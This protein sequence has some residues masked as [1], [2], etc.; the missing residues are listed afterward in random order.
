MSVRRVLSRVRAPDEDGAEARAWAVVRTSYQNRVPNRQRRRRVRL[1]LLCML[2]LVAIAGAVTLSPAGTSVARWVKDTLGVRHAADKLFAL[3]SPGSV[4]VSGPRGTW[5]VTADGS[6]RRLGSWSDASW[7]PHGLYIAVTRGRDIA[8]ADPHGRVQWSLVRPEVADPSWYPP[9]GWRVAYL[10]G[11]TV[12]V[13]AGDGA[14]DHLLARDVARVAP[15]WRPGHPYELAYVTRAGRLV[16]REAAS[17]R[18]VWSTRPNGHVQKLDWSVDGARLLVL[19]HTRAEVYVPGRGMAVDMQPGGVVAD[20]SLSPDGRRLALIVGGRLDR[21]LV[22]GIASPLSRP[23]VAFTGS[24]L[25]QLDWSPNGR[26]LLVAWSAADQW[27]FV[28]ATGRPRIAAVSHIAQQFGA[29][30]TGQ[31]FPRLAGW[32]CARWTQ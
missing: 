32:C 17:G 4:L 22:A 6:L 3:P 31:G 20:G 21:V 10:A 30:A 11:R 27:L 9:N 28:H 7:S 15:A 24:G 19:T 26:W 16:M 14:D 12:R 1:A 2:P 13:V 29:G 18:V 5:I 8:A 25:S 23:E